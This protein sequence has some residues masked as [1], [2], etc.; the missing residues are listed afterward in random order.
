MKLETLYLIDS[1]EH[2]IDSN[3]LPPRFWRSLKYECVYLHAWETGSEAKAG[4]GRC[5]RRQ[6]FWN[7][8]RRKLSECSA[9]LVGVIMR[10][11]GCDAS[12]ALRTSSV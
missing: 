8:E 1:N 9:H 3:E 12:V 10:R 4:V 7:Q 6:S 5:V 2:L 11:V